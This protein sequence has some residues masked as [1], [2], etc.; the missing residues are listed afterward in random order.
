MQTALINI[1]PRLK[2][3]ALKA[4]KGQFAL[5]GADVG[6]GNKGSVRTGSE[7][8]SKG[9]KLLEGIRDGW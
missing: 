7:E 4:K 5:F 2:P 8:R 3:L 9:A 1:V 6:G